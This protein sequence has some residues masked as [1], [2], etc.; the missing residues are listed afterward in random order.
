MIFVK[1]C[2]LLLLHDKSTKN[3]RSFY[4]ILD[5]NPGVLTFSFHSVHTFEKICEKFYRF[6]LCSVRIL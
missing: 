1:Q 2:N 5:Y 3:G 6:G 4:L